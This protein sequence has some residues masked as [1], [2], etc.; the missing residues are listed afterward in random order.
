MKTKTQ[1]KAGALIGNTNQN[2]VPVKT[3]VKAGA[4]NAY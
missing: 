3:K 2:G 4:L 1:T